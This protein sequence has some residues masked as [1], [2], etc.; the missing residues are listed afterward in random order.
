MIDTSSREHSH[1][2]TF[3]ELFKEISTDWEGRARD[4]RTRRWQQLNA[5]SKGA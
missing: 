3:D 2:M 4:L 5:Q 1:T